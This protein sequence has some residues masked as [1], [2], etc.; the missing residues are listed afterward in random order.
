MVVVCQKIPLPMSIELACVLLSIFIILW[1]VDVVDKHGWA[2]IELLSPLLVYACL[3]L[4]SSLAQSL[5]MAA[6]TISNY[7]NRAYALNNRRVRLL[8]V[9][10]EKK[11]AAR[12]EQPGQPA[13]PAAVELSLVAVTIT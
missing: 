11:A 13:Q 6:T 3:L 4:V 7:R 10:E 1:A 9:P 8:D 5:N 12:P 2:H